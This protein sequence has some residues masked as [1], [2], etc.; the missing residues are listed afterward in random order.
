MLI[1]RVRASVPRARPTPDHQSQLTLNF[2]VS[3]DISLDVFLNPENVM[4][5]QIVVREP[6]TKVGEYPS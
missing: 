4:N 6:V 3:G 1:I 2:A 5:P